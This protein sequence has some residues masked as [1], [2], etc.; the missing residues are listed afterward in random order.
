[1]TVTCESRLEN[2]I[3]IHEKSFLGGFCKWE[4]SWR[5]KT[6]KTLLG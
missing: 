6:Q 4:A 1:M 2:A 3:F 5:G